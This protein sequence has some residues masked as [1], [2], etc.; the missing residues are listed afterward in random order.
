MTDV[1]CAA[2]YCISMHI[3]ST[4]HVTT[5][6]DDE[7]SP[8]GVETWDYSDGLCTVCIA[9]MLHVCQFV[10]RGRRAKTNIKH[11]KSIPSAR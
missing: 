6:V 9:C 10:L 3:M 1:P 11:V 5:C 8:G 7:T 4:Y 2:Q